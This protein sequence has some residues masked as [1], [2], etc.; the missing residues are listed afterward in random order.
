MKIYFTNNST[1]QNFDNFL[2]K[3]DF[4][5]EDKLEIFT[6]SHWVNTNPAGLVLAA[7][8]AKSVGKKHATIDDNSA[9]SGAYLDAMGLY[10]FVSTVSPFHI[11]KKEPSGRYIPITNIKTEAEQTKFL[12]DIIPLLHLGREESLAIRYALYE[13]VRNVLE[14]SMSKDGALVAAQY[15]K[16]KNKI[17]IGIC[18]T[19][20]GVKSSLNKYHHPKNDLEALRLALMPG[21][22]G[23]TSRPDGTEQNAGAG[24]FI[25]KSLARITRSYF[26]IYSGDSLYKL[27]KYDKRVQKPRINADPFDDRF[28]YKDNLPNFNGT[29]VGVDIALDDD[30]NFADLLET[31]K[32]TYSSA[33]RERKR[34]QYKRFRFV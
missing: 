9:A 2:S 16:R 19:G 15:N 28:S 14:H 3:I 12:T 29:L 17:S 22:S 10:D 1:L 27:L 32:K 34:K 7:A 6:D 31:I 30:E 5:D 13:L 4:S 24:L 21:V 20:I 8:L 25:V 26:I 18:D 33:V 11:D 23:T